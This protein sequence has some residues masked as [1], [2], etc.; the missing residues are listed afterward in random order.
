[1]LILFGQGMYVGSGRGW[2]P[3]QVQSLMEKKKKRG[4][5]DGVNQLFVRMEMDINFFES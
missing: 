4:M 3:V 5:L 2:V 1:M